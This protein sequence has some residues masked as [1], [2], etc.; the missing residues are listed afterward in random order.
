MGKLDFPKFTKVEGHLILHALIMMDFGPEN[1]RDR[2]D[3]R[4]GQV[5]DHGPLFFI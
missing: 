1:N 2:D 4:S 5:A 3:R